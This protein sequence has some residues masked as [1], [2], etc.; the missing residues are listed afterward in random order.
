MQSHAIGVKP[1]SN[2]EASMVNYPQK[3]AVWTEHQLSFNFIHQPAILMLFIWLYSGSGYKALVEVSRRSQWRII[4]II[5][6][7]HDSGHNIYHG[8]RGKP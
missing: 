7:F 4:T 6:V 3:V 2:Q 8:I 5:P 1:E